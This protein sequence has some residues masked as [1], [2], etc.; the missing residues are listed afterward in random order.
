MEKPVQAQRLVWEANPPDVAEVLRG[1][2]L[3]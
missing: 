3:K 2:N 1:A